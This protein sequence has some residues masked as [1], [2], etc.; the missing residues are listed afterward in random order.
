MRFF[1]VGAL[2]AA[3][4]ACS[5][6]SGPRVRETATVSLVAEDLSTCALTTNGSAFCW[7]A[8]S[9]GQLGIGDPWECSA[10]ANGCVEAHGG[11]SHLLPVAVSGGHRFAALSGAGNFTCAASP[12]GQSFCWGGTWY[13]TLHDSVPVAVPAAPLFASISA[14]A[15]DACGLMPSGKAYC[16]GDNA[17]GEVGTG[18]VATHA[19]PV[20]VA[21][22]LTF[23][24][25]TVGPD[26]ACGLTAQGNAYCWGAAG[27]GEIGNGSTPPMLQTTPA[28]VSGGLHF[29]SLSA[30]NV[31]TC[32]V[33]TGNKAYCWG[34]NLDGALGD[35]AVIH[36]TTPT[37]VAG[38]IAFSSIS[39]WG[40]NGN[41]GTTCGLT[42][43]G[44]A[45][46]WGDDS[47]G[48]LGG[49]SVTPLGCNAGRA[50]CATSPVPVSGNLTFSTI[51]VGGWHVCGVTTDG[52]I[53]C[54]GANDYGQLGNGTTA[55]S[56]VPQRVVGV[57]AP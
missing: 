24:T 2:V 27:F 56:P 36:T 46:C 48:Q 13:G 57:S 49:A 55:D 14:G 45:Y 5:D 9:A 34:F 19:T 38:G 30:G 51:A 31:Y 1:I 42:P 50:T 3:I 40:T 47:R 39:T 26:H 43:S 37:A 53:Y 52:G 41:S 22:G 10:Y 21:G 4:V 25:L 35:S 32:G 28:P 15:L 17:S 7:G 54:W 23:S 18:D 8:D 12:E 33:T 20:A 29:K 44:K 6:Q 11:T 16:W